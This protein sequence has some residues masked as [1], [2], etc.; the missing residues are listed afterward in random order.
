M[1]DFSK[2][3][4]KRAQALAQAL[5]LALLAQ[6]LRADAIR[7][8][9]KRSFLSATENIRDENGDHPPPV[10]APAAPGLRSSR[11]GPGIR[12]WLQF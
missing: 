4:I 7:Y 6:A 8:L 3:L 12:D 11:S 9:G 1:E 10:P 2:E 5:A